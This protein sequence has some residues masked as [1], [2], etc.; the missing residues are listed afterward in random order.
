MV[1]KTY[2]NLAIL[3]I[4]I[5]SYTIYNLNSLSSEP[6]TVME[7]PD[8]IELKISGY[9]TIVI[10]IFVIQRIAQKILN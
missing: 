2:K 4:A 10:S 7:R 9:P 5:G 3:G 8:L 6:K 1:K